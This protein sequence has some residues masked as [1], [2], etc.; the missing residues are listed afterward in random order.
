[1]GMKPTEWRKERG[2][3]LDEAGRLAGIAGVNPGRTYQRY[4]SGRRFPP[5]GVVEAILLASGGSVDP[6][7]W[8]RVCVE[9]REIRRAANDSAPTATE[10]A[11]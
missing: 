11:A 7:D 9:F 3:S 8:H 5:V 1:M 4:E 6:T 2:L 10:T